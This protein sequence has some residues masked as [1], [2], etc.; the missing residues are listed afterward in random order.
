MSIA[1]LMYCRFIVFV[2][3]ILTQKLQCRYYVLLKIRKVSYCALDY[4]NVIG[5]D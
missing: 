5:V 2:F 4:R 3:T 1:I